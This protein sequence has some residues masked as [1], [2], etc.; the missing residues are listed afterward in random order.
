MLNADRQREVEQATDAF[1]VRAETL[2]GL[3][4]PPVTVRF[5][6]KGRAAGMFR[7]RHGN[8][9]IRYN[10]WVFARW[11]ADNL[12]ETVPHEVAHYVVS[13]LHRRRTKPHGP[14]WRAVMQAFGVAPRV[15]CGYRPEDVADLPRRRMREHAYACGCMQHRLSSI[16]HNRIRRGKA[17]YH[18][19]KCRRPLRPVAAKE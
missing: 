8:P 18:C 16:R 13:R 15:T 1:I 14:E 17:S 19:R 4:L 7:V 9:E 5:D 10:P 12:A 2:F 3:R 11:Y 6:L